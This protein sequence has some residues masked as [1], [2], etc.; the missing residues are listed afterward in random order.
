MLPMRKYYLDSI[1]DDFMDDMETTRNPFDIMKCD[2]YEKDGA[3]H[4]EADIPGF[5]KEDISVECEDGYITISAE[6]K[7]ENEEKDEDK[8]YLKRE[9]FYGKTT[10]KFYVGDIDTNDIKA[11]FKDGILN[12]V[13][14]KEEKQPNKKSIDIL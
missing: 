3:Y 5:K 1:F 9:R 6:K 11:E 14:P 7:E 4:I 2:I 12:I 10:R 13:V 8:K